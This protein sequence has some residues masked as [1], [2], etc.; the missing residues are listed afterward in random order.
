MFFSPIF[1]LLLDEP[2]PLEDMTEQLEKA[3]NSKIQFQQ[4]HLPGL[5]TE[6]KLSTS[7]NQKKAQNQSKK[8][9]TETV[10][11]ADSHISDNSTVKSSNVPVTNES[12]KKKSS[13][14]SFGGFRKGFLSGSKQSSSTCSSSKRSQDKVS[15][16]GW[17][18][19]AVKPADD[20]IRPKQQKSSSLEF[21]EVQEAMKESFPFLNTDSKLLF[22]LWIKVLIYP[23]LKVRED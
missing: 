22:V 23:V 1:S 3:R 15:S 20:V 9:A 6:P 13:S 19:D 7:S 8:K 17:D 4:A 2:P 11:H 14:S 12:S 21:P 18:K 16:Q 5:K 10:H